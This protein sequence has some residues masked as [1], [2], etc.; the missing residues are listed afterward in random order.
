MKLAIIECEMKC[1]SELS[2]R[3][4]VLTRNMLYSSAVVSRHLRLRPPIRAITSSVTVFA[5]V[6]TTFG[7]LLIKVTIMVT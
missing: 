5:V 1:T 4:L 7:W 3:Q 2:P 6:E